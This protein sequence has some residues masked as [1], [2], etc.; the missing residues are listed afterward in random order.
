MRTSGYPARFLYRQVFSCWRVFPLLFLFSRSSPAACQNLVANGGFEEINVCTEYKATCSPV[1]WFIVTAGLQT[2]APKEGQHSL[3]LLYG[4]VYDATK[5]SFPYTR[6]LCTLQPGKEYELLFWLN[7]GIVPFSSLEVLLSP[8]DPARIRRNRG[9]VNF[10]FSLTPADIVQK[11]DKGW[12]QLQRR[13]KV[14]EEMNFL[15]LGNMQPAGSYSRHLEKKLE[16]LSGNIV[17]CLDDL[18]LTDTDST[19]NTCPMYAAIREAVSAEHHRHTPYIYLDSLPVDV[20]HSP[21]SQAV[22]PESQAVAPESITAAPTAPPK[23]DTLL[24]PGLLFATNS[25]LI[26]ETYSKLL[27]SLVTRIA[28]KLPSKMEIDG[29]TDNAGSAAFNKELSLQRAQSIRNYIVHKLPGLETITRIEGEGMDHPR[30][31]N[32]SPA[33]K[34]QN[35]RVEIILIY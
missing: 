31:P 20:K 14:E 23:P 34:A 13:F 21:P 9:K 17:F 12:I 8:G 18:H 26:N 25:S 7:T 4:N 35:R 29:H 30:A 19:G 15:L 2:V 11:D 5:R 3:A 27:D 6:T 33:N 16:K 32:D 10:S 28:G 24:V 1:A 22:A